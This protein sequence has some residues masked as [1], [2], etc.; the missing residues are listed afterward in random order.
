MCA[1]KPATGPNTL[2]NLLCLFICELGTLPPG[3]V[4]I[5]EFS[6]GV[7]GTSKSEDGP[8]SQAYRAWLRIR[9]GELKQ[10]SLEC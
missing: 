9:V 10:G 1:E 5:R 8:C 3:Q 7:D 4:E 6:P 2:A